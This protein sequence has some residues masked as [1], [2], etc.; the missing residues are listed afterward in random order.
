MN[1]IPYF[2]KIDTNN[3][4]DNYTIKKNEQEKIYVD[5]NN[6]LSLYSS[7]QT[8]LFQ[9]TSVFTNIVFL[10]PNGISCAYSDVQARNIIN[11]SG[12]TNPNNFNDT[13]GTN[14]TFNSG[15]FIIYDLGEI[16]SN[17]TI[18]IRS[19]KNLQVYIS[20]DNGT[21]WSEEWHMSAVDKNW[22]EQTIDLSAYSGQTIKVCFGFMTGGNVQN[23]RGWYVDDVK[24]VY[25]PKI[26][27]PS[28]TGNVGD[29][30]VITGNGFV[31]NEAVTVTADTIYT[32]KTV[33]S[34]SLTPDTNGNLNVTL[35]IPNMPKGVYDLR[36]FGT[37]EDNEAQKNNWLIIKPKLTKLDPCSG[38]NVGGAVVKIAGTGFTPG[39]ISGNEITI[40]GQPTTYSAPITVASN[41][42]L[43]ESSITL[44]SLNGGRKDMVIQGNLFSDVYLVTDISSIIITPDSGDGKSGVTATIIGKNFTPGVQVPTNSIKIGNKNTTHTYFSISSSGAFTQTIT[45]PYLG[46]GYQLLSVTVNDGA[47]HTYNNVYK[48]SGISLSPSYGY[49]ISNQSFILTG[50]GFSEGVISENSIKLGDVTTI[51]NKITVLSDGT[52][53]DVSITIPKPLPGL[54]SGRFYNITINNEN[55]K[56]FDNAYRVYSKYT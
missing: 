29:E 43:P 46:S 39:V 23:R 52:F 37:S 56:T 4:I 25:T 22:K 31:P 8:S 42:D 34:G 21:T 5:D 12:V 53:S 33:K 17:I 24:V 6:T 26:T 40:D 38:S 48:V 41:G 14:A 20:N 9:N 13:P 47:E 11:Y 36:V 30:L 50:K 28:Y 54:L 2:Q 35:I 16:K 51:H 55:T 19:N 27:S 32:L 10:A 44:P 15:G 18:V 1:I 3:I 7:I 49:G 45:L